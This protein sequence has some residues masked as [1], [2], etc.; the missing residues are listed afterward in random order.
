MGFGIFHTLHFDLFRKIYSLKCLC[1]STHLP[2]YLVN[3]SHDTTATTR[4]RWRGEYPTLFTWP[5]E[6]WLLVRRHSCELRTVFFFRP[7][8]ISG[9]RRLF[10]TPDFTM[11]I[12]WFARVPTIVDNDCF[13]THFL[14]ASF[15]LNYCLPLKDLPIA[16]FVSRCVESK[17]VESREHWSR[18]LTRENG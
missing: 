14:A 7:C 15:G 5:E 12:V 1:S 4:T 11:S 18:Q 8:V 6:G 9:A 3:H 13:S 16:K 2:T 17:S 10:R